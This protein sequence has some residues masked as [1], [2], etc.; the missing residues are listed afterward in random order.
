MVSAP[1]SFLALLAPSTLFMCC[2]YLFLC[3]S[4]DTDRDQEKSVECVDKLS[5]R[6][7][8]SSS[9]PA[10]QPAFY[11]NMHNFTRFQHI[12]HSELMLLLLFLLLLRFQHYS[13]YFSERSL[14]FTIHSE[15]FPCHV[16]HILND[17][18]MFGWLLFAVVVVFTYM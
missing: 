7:N 2:C 18:V 15:P 1:R 4:S 14:S 5:E 11:I 16:A 8:T 6:T 17:Y 10:A 9:S 13:F 12:R 3:G